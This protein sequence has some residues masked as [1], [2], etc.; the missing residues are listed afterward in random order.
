[1]KENGRPFA[2]MTTVSTREN[3]KIGML[4]LLDS[5]IRID[6][7][8]SPHCSDFYNSLEYDVRREGFVAEETVE[9]V[10]QLDVLLRIVR[11]RSVTF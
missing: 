5:I 4:R 1:M 7:G 3:N 8:Q 10:L 6:R 9:G 2:I 11:K